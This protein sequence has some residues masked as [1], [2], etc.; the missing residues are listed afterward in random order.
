VTTTDANGPTG[1]TD[2]D[3]RPQGRTPAEASPPLAGPIGAPLRALRRAALQPLSAPLHTARWAGGLG[4]AALRWVRLLPAVERGV[5]TTAPVP[6]PPADLAGDPEPVQRREDG[7]GPL[8]HRVYRVRITAPQVGAATLL[9]RIAADPNRVAP[10]DISRW[11]KTRGAPGRLTVGDEF[12]VHLPGPWEG[13]V[14]VVAR[15][16][17][18]FTVITLRGH[19]EAGENTFRARDE[20]GAV[21]FEVETWA[22]CGDPLLRLL[23]EPLWVA[24]EAQLHMWVS[25]CANAVE[26]AGGRRDGRIRVETATVPGT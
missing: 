10:Q 11:E 1:R 18:S 2:P 13:P 6:P 3:A 17:T 21:V 15:D 7:S 26:L 8:H 19:M 9:E 20:D 5:A 12:V 4:V 23:Y 14:R 22:R 24:R 25:T 16:A